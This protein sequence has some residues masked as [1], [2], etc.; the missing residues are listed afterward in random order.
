MRIMRNRVQQG[1]PSISSS[2]SGGSKDDESPTKE[3]HRI[4]EG[5][6]EKDEP[7]MKLSDDIDQVRPISVVMRPPFY[8][9]CALLSHK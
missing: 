7:A 6:D 2:S 8:G 1:R 5:E 3:Q 9:G 4:K